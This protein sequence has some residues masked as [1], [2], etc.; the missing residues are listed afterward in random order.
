Y[1]ITVTA[2]AGDNST[3]GEYTTVIKYTKPEVVRDLTVTDFTTSSVSLNW[4][5]PAGKR[6][7]FIVQLTD[8]NL[9][10]TY[11]VTETNINVTNLTAGVRYEIT[12]TAVAGDNSTKGEYTTVIKY[13]KPEVV[14]D[15]TVTDFTTSSVSLNW[16]EPAGKRS[17]FIVQLT[18]G[19]LTK[20]YNVT[21]TN[22]NVTN[23][24]A[25]VRYE[26][27]V[28]AVAGDNSTKGEYTTVIKYTKPEVVR[29]LTVTDFTTSSVSLNWTEPAGKRSFFIVQLTDG[30]LTKTYNLTETNINVTNLTAGVRY[31]ITVT[32]V[33]GDNSTKG[34]SRTLSKYTKPEVVRD[35]TVTDFTTSSVSLNWTE[36]AGKR[37]FFIVQLTDGNVTK[38]YNVT[39]TNINM[40]SLTAGVR[41]EITVTAVAGDNSTKGEY[42]TVI[43]YTSKLRVKLNES[44]CRRRLPTKMQFSHFYVLLFP[45][46]FLS[47]PS[48]FPSEPGEIIAKTV[49]TNTVSI[50]LN[51]TPPSGK[52]FKYRVEWHIGGTLMNMS[53]DHPSAILSD[54]IPG[55]IYTITITA[56]N[57]NND[58]GKP[59]TFTSVTKPAVVSNLTVFDVTTSSV[60][61]NWTE[62]AGKRSFFIVQLTNGNLTETYNWQDDNSTKGEYTTV[63]KYTRP[64]KPVD[65]KI[66]A[67]GTDYLTI[68]WILP[69]GNAE[70]FLVKISNEELSY[71]HSNTARNTTAQ[72]T[73]LHPGRI[74]NITVTAVAGN[75]SDS[76][77]T[78]FATLTFL[79]FV[80]FV[81][82]NPVVNLVASPKSNTSI[83]VHWAYPHGVQQ[84]YNYFVQTHNQTGVQ[85]DTLVNNNSVD[86]P[87]LEPGSRYNITVT[88]IAAPETKSTKEHTFSYTMPKA[89]TNLKGD[90]VNTTAICLTWQRQ[91]DYKPSYSYLV[92]AL[93][94]DVVV[95]NASTETETYTFFNLSPGQL[96]V[97]A[98]FTVVDGVRST[99]ETYTSYTK[100]EIVSGIL[101]IGSTTNM[102]VSW[103]LAVGQVVSYTV[104]L[105]KDKHQVASKMD[106]TN[107]TA[108]TAF[109]GL[110]PGVLYCVVVVAKSGLLENNSSSVC[111]ATFPTPP[112][113]I[114][115][116]SQTVKSI[117]FTWPFPEDMDRN[118]YNFSV[119]TLNGSFLTENNWFLLDGLQ[120][121]SNYSITV[122]TVGVKTYRS[123]AVTASNYTRP[124]CV[125]MLT[126]TEI[127]TNSVTLVW[128][129]QDNKS[130]YTYMVW[131]SN[132]SL[133]ALKTASGTT[134]TITGLLSGSNYNFTVT[135]MTAD[136]TQAASV[137]VSY[138]TRPYS[139][140]DLEAKTLNTTAVTL[141]WMKPLEYKDEYT[142]LVQTTL[143][144]SQNKSLTQEVA[145]FS[146]LTPGT[147]CSF[148]VI[149]KAADGIEGQANC[150]FQYTKPEAVQP[151]ITNEGSNSSIL[152]SWTKP[153]GSVESYKVY[154]NSSSAVVVN[155]TKT[156]VL[157]ESLSA[158]RLYTAVVFTCSGPFNASSKFVTN[159]TLPNPPGSIEIL[160]KT[161]SS[162][163]IRWEEAPLMTAAL[164]YY[165]LTY[166]GGNNTIVYNTN[167]TFDSLLSGTSY[168]ISVATVGPM[169]FESEAV[170][171]HM[172]TTRP[173]SVKSLMASTEE[174]T[175]TVT[176]NLPDE[177]KESYRYNLSWQSSDNSFSNSNITGGTWYD[178]KN[179]VPGSRYN[180]TVT[181]E[182]SD[183]TKGAPVWNTTCTNASSVTN[184]QC[185]GPDTADAQLILN[186]TNP[187]GKYSSFQVTVTQDN[188]ITHEMNI[189][190]SPYHAVSN[191]SHYTNYMLNVKT[192]SCG[193][194][195]T[196]VLLICRTGI[197][198]P[199]I[200]DNFVSLSAVT[201]TAY[202][203]FSV[204]I[205][206]NLLSNANGPVTHVGVLV[207]DNLTANATDLVRYLNKTYA[208][209]K[210]K[211]T[212][213]YL[214]TV[215]EKKYQSRSE[216]QHL[217]IE[218][219]NESKWKGYTNGPLDA[220]GKYL[221]AIVLFTR[222]TLDGEHVD[223]EKSLVS[224]THF[225]QTVELPE[226]P[227]YISIAIGATLGIFFL[228]FIILIGFIIYWKRLSKKEAPDIQI[229][230]MSV[231]I[232]PLNQRIQ[233]DLGT[234]ISLPKLI[235][236]T[237][238]VHLSRSVA[239]R[240]EDY[241]AYYRKQKADSNCG[242]AEEFEDLKLVGTGQSKTSA[243]TLENK[244]KN[245]Y[246]NV[247]PYDS[248]RV[249]LSIIHGSPYDDYI[250]AN[251]MPGCN[252]R[253]EFIAAQGPLPTTVNEFWR[254]IWEKN[255]Q[256]LVMLT[257]C[258]EQ[259]R[260]K[261]EQYWNSSTKHFDNITVT[262]TSEIPLD[263]WTIREFDIKNMKTAE[264]R[265]VR[266][267]HFTAWPDHGVPQTTELLIS[268][269]HLV[270]EHMNQ[271][272][273]NSPTVV[274]CSAGVGRTGT[275][276]A[277]DR[278]IFQ[279]ERENIVDVYGI[280]HDLRMHRPLMVQTEDQYVFLN[281]C[282]LDIIR[283]RTGTNVDLIYQNAAAL[284]IYE[285]IEPKRGYHKNGYQNA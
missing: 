250:N 41:Y 174:K 189:T 148:C 139:I 121:G 221:Y 119:S 224:V 73:N 230:S 42:T 198:N 213:V 110:K 220:R 125:S 23:L 141:T 85:F 130:D 248:S 101:A 117:N 147:K 19:N 13:T 120:S 89:V 108:N 137:T 158:G 265:S 11:N 192:L 26:I 1:E 37:S 52:V 47:S 254:M 136:G 2:V 103:T 185:Q 216:M 283:S 18:D 281:Q 8:G 175:I 53:T 222:L 64:E 165:R 116:V 223:V 233:P 271:Y 284:S 81:V 28:T 279:I 273:R 92:K 285:N 40:T 59:C 129:Q 74:F 217:T 178:I 24:T 243:L 150:T 164:F 257:R 218:V 153:P 187:S 68:S 77:A 183:G 241:E 151:F 249:K 212:Q 235:T 166:Q 154:L 90:N 260:V 173:F 56:I 219:G 78:S 276:I 35:L 29:Y 113:P 5:E 239:V 266:H 80:I 48:F 160:T 61:L 180:F 122:V 225:Y 27:T 155:S 244:P 14:R 263:D 54:L 206:D 146:G 72:F 32:A 87:N 229:H 202:N 268:F 105:Y 82:P 124:Y 62:P 179:L 264:I 84:Y 115:V 200:P 144:G 95:Q 7:F 145:Q 245:R 156:S 97:F 267:F 98:V 157:F 277:I 71:N 58:S 232:N 181:T 199:P 94:Y 69:K 184:I 123:T 44:T 252:S 135:T 163:G 83:E 46:P 251:Y 176:W 275:F 253:K 118:Q 16:T 106:L 128:K 45:P 228:L 140:R 51:W 10:K 75:F 203:K 55:T 227:V 109:T 30:N 86:I 282:A 278:L 31:E 256:T 43:K 50:S 66:T 93:L 210:A 12:V 67:R 169:G 96:Y 149:V 126:Q 258:N 34:E 240:V 262:M 182:T 104:L 60:S 167:Y 280:V 22:I 214:A 186:W 161:T 21:E 20:T 274:H 114:M 3:K 168:N 133:V 6:S 15:L 100:P 102:S 193:L 205:K 201:S 191:L 9:T 208:E 132:G 57:E 111:N 142:Y 259:G 25:G 195:S 112:G 190:S 99:R 91:S 127:T 237:C 4:T 143:C 138:F 272:S 231:S 171:I 194:P 70:N 177:Y 107:S 242:F 269:R 33:A 134:E 234:E 236:I 238:G 211:E 152:V 188:K 170:H 17:F 270:R 79:R 196:P 88:T 172:A 255:V 226:N 204:Q 207:T 261:C 159:A 38:T 162:I 39:E 36:P 247:L 215:T 65:I 63:I 197:T 246:N 209:W 131:A 76:S 49:T